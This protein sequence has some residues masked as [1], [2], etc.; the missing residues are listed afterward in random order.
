MDSN[1][2]ASLSEGGGG[3]C[4][5]P[6]SA[7]STSRRLKADSPPSGGVPRR[8]RSAAPMPA[9]LPLIAES[10]AASRT[11][12]RRHFSI[13]LKYL[14]SSIKAGWEKL[15]GVLDAALMCLA[16]FPELSA[17]LSECL[18][19]DTVPHLK[20]YRAALIVCFGPLASLIVFAIPMPG[21][22]H[23]SV[24]Q[25]LPVLFIIFFQSTFM[26][27]PW[28]N[29]FLSDVWGDERV[30]KYFKIGLMAGA[31][32][33]FWLG[34]VPA[35]TPYWPLPW[36]PLIAGATLSAVFGMIYYNVPRDKRSAECRRKIAMVFVTL[37]G[38]EA[39]F[40]ISYPILYHISL[41]LNG[42]L[43]L[44]FFLGFYVFRKVFENVAKHY[45][46]MFCIDC[47]P[48]IVLF[49]M[50]GYEFFISSAISDVPEV[51]LAMLLIALD[52]AENFFHIYCIYRAG[53]PSLSL[54]NTSRVALEDTEHDLQREGDDEDQPSLLSPSD[55]EHP[56]DYSR[57][58]PQKSDSYHDAEMEPPL[59][60]SAVS[61]PGSQLSASGKRDGSP[62]GED[63]EA[64]IKASLH[65]VQCPGQVESDGV[66]GTGS[67]RP[68]NCISSS[69][70]QCSEFSPIMPSM[71]GRVAESSDHGIASAGRKR[72]IVAKLS[73]TT[74]RWGIA[75]RGSS[76]S[77]LSSF[78]SLLKH[79]T[80][81]GLQKPVRANLGKR[82]PSPGGN[83]L[84]KGP[85]SIDDAQ[86]IVRR[87]SHESSLSS[88]RSSVLEMITEVIIGRSKGK[89]AEKLSKRSLSVMTIAICEEMV[90]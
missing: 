85:F 29:S 4:L 23:V 64:S 80:G 11:S 33:A 86:T 22:I 32:Q 88:R 14:R 15:T 72:E 47:Y 83:G 9:P 73:N 48:M 60:Q 59:P 12:E 18:L 28:S 31:W 5:T 62:R 46:R 6:R 16:D 13:T 58:M 66:C 90:E 75:R 20:L 50:Y 44:C 7:S 82:S 8:T 40:G 77:T 68:K 55:L 30:A 21:P 3:L 2:R 37:G 25:W 57:E 10:S 56:A 49:G 51:W 17:E 89:S 76:M 43:K 42:L 54:G 84:V 26:L 36:M 79:M 19:R 35:F 24:W 69:G 81:S 78:T 27:A 38:G 65:A 70:A 41:E 52:L 71:N 45:A 87:T 61:E 74:E 53:D 1:N 63:G 39:I 67:G 34:V